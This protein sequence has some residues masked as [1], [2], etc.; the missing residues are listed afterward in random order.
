VAY[1][2]FEE[3]EDS[4]LPLLNVIVSCTSQPLAEL[5]E[6]ESPNRKM[7]HAQLQ[8]KQAEWC[9]DSE[10]LPIYGFVFC[11]KEYLLRKINKE[12]IS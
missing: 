3:A 9:C 7:M 11:L 6:I 1:V 8:C 10:A 5:Q 2:V 12:N 4:S